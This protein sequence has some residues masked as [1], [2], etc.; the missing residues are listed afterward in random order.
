MLFAKQSTSAAYIVGPILDATGAEY[1]GAVLADLSISKNGGTQTA[2]ASP[3]LLAFSANGQ[4]S[5]ALGTG[6]TDTLGRVQIT[7]NKSTYQMPTL[8]LMI[9]PATV[10][11]A[12]VT[13]AVNATGGLAGATGAITTF[14]GAISTY[15]GA[16]TSGTT[17][18]LTRIGGSITIS[19]GKVAAT[20]GSS[21]YTGNTVQTGDSFAR[22]G[23]AGVGLTAVALTATQAFNNTGTW[24]GNLVGLIG[25]IAGTLQT[26]DAFNTSLSSTHG[27][28]AWT[29]A[30]GF[31]VPGDAM[32]LTSAYDAAKTA[33]QAGDAMTLDTTQVV[34]LANVTS[35]V[36][37]TV[38]TALLS[39]RAQ[40]AGVWTLIGTALLLK[41]PDG[42][43]FRSFTL[44]SATI[45]TSRT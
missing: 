31:A 24:T 7:C 5:L 35:D 21:D 29:T 10:Y 22:I 45:P 13:N 40:G 18:L 39:A 2:L 27:A 26:L 1:A 42:T 9:L 23:A 25:G 30:T 19:G 14:A 15:A 33:A 34:P 43:T 37:V 4:Y 32:T 16:D 38:G 17:T 6:N 44:D 3:A 28:G 20:M 36:T 8:E 11:D 12:L 41:N